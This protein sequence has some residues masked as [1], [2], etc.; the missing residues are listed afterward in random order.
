MFYAF[1]TKPLK[2]ITAHI[3][4]SI[5]STQIWPQIWL[6]YHMFKLKMFLF[7]TPEL[8]LKHVY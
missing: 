1:Q 4:Y 6:F 7:L 2:I 5:I 8:T 3:L